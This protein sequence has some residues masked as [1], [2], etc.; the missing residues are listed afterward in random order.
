[1]K[2]I[3]LI[4]GCSMLFSGCA[5]RGPSIELPTI[6]LPSVELNSPVRVVSPSSSYHDDDHHHKSGKGCPPGLAKQGRC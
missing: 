4:I 3:F 6:G 2:N 5:V 1:M